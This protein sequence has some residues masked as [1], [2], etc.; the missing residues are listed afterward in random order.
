MDE[1]PSKAKMLYDIVERAYNVRFF[2]CPPHKQIVV[3][4]ILKDGS[5]FHVQGFFYIEPEFINLKGFDTEGNNIDL[6]IHY[7]ACQLK[8]FLTDRESNKVAEKMKF[9]FDVPKE[10]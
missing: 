5:E 3:N 8:F 4:A 10:K 7:S 6:L 2:Q 9:G 1:T